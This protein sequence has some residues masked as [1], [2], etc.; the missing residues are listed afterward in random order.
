MKKY[1]Y[2]TVLAAVVTAVI[3]FFVRLPET[4]NQPPQTVLAITF[5]FP[6]GY[7][8]TQGAPFV[9]TWR[10]ESPEGVL[11]VP[12]KDKNFKPL[13]SPYKLV[14]SPAVGSSA[15]VLNAR[16]Y[17]CHKTS[18]MCFQE[19]FQA[20]VPLGVESTSPVSYIWEII[21]KQT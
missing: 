20:R 19:D 1:I 10:T 16:L 13:V 6:L 4:T 18:R 7:E 21:P 5:R 12:V 2:G 11:S 15:V 14:F 8:F 3:I 17:Y 9:L